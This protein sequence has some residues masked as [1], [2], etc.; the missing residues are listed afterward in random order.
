MPRGDA[1]AQDRTNLD[2]DRAHVTIETVLSLA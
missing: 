2:R 1:A